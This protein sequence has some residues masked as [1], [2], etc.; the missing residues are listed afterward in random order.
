[1]VSELI[2]RLTG[3][4]KR[5]STTPGFP[6]PHQDARLAIA[7]T[8]CDEAIKLVAKRSMRCVTAETRIL[9]NQV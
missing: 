1:V 6:P 4:G 5:P 7:A 3:M 2:D 9:E 8:R